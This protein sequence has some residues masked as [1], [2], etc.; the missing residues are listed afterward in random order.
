MDSVVHT[1]RGRHHYWAPL[2]EPGVLAPYIEA[3]VA[4]LAEPDVPRF[5][6]FVVRG[7]SGLLVGPILAVRLGKALAVVRKERNPHDAGNIRLVLGSIG[8]TWVF[9]DDF[10]C[11]GN[12]LHQ[13]VK[14]IQALELDQRGQCIGALL[15]KW[16]IKRENISDLL[17]I[18]A[19]GR[20]WLS[21]ETLREM[22]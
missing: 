7:A 20:G 15:Y 19:H 17:H 3:S 14:H 9:L 8:R 21:Y 5:D 11:G 1:L 2:T 6:G 18:G 13:C 12:T 4:R 22:Y 10:I 16:T